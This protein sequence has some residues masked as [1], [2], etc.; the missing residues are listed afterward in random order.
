M[1]SKKVAQGLALFSLWFFI[2]S[3][4]FPLT[5]SAYP[6]TATGQELNKFL[7]GLD[8]ANRWLPNRVVDWK[9]GKSLSRYSGPAGTHC[10]TFVAAAATKLGV[11]ILTPQHHG[12]MLANAQFDWLEHKGD[13]HGWSSV[14]DHQLA[15]QIANQ[16][17]LVVV[18]Y[19]NPNR[20]RS[21][22]VAIIR[23][24]NK[25]AT[26][27]AEKGPQIIQAGRKNYTSTNLS[28]GFRRHNVAF[29]NGRIVYYAHSTPY[30]QV[31]ASR[32]SKSAHRSA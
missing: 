7:D 1:V 4:F 13:V 32:E 25:T 12:A 14:D 26:E 10:S 27:I 11:D 15:Q 20:N 29:N 19:A 21:G 16:G 23:P 9:S 2:L 5:A 17:C 31:V 30:C 18:A 28:N 22:H 3:T 6:V 8:V 24:S